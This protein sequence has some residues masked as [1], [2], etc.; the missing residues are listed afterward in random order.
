M[1]SLADYLA[2]HQ[3]EPPQATLTL[4][5]MQ[6]LSVDPEL[7]AYLANVVLFRDEDNPDVTVI[8]SGVAAELPN[9]GRIEDGLA[10]KLKRY[11]GPEAVKDLTLVIGVEALVD[12]QQ[13]EAFREA[14]REDGLPFKNILINSAEG[15][16]RL[17]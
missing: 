13:V 12:A 14:H 9:D 11:G 10:L 7:S 4:D 8:T 5:F 2:V 16:M 17:K 1:E 15:T 3:P 6:I